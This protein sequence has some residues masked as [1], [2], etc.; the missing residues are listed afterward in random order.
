MVACNSTAVSSLHIQLENSACFH[1]QVKALRPA[2]FSDPRSDSD[3]QYTEDHVKFVQ[4]SIIKKEPNKLTLLGSDRLSDP[5][6]F[7]CA[8]G[9]EKGYCPPTTSLP[10][11]HLG[12]THTFQSETEHAAPT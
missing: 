5:L 11:R 6:T 8:L 1:T 10:A 3:M 7:K 9:Y 2:L 4:T 12:Q